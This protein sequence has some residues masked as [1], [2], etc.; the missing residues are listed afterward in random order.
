MKKSLIE[1]AFM[2]EKR[3]KVLLLLQDGPLKMG[4]ILK[5]LDTNRQGLLPQI[6]ILEDYHLIIKKD[7]QCSLTTIG[8]MVVKQMSPLL[9]IVAVLDNDIDYWGSREL[10][11]I[12]PGLLDRF[13]ELGPCTVIE[14]DI[15]DLYEM[16][17]D[18]SENIRASKSMNM[19]TTFL[20]PDFFTL[21]ADYLEH[22][23][24]ISMVLSKEL[25]HKISTDYRD[26]FKGLMKRGRVNM[27]VS[28]LEMPFLSVAYSDHCIFLR[29]LKKKL[30]FDSKQLMCCSPCALAWGKDFFNNYLEHSAPM[31]DI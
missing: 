20:Y 22:G 3:K 1:I 7:D 25:A 6:K 27:F 8:E 28:R 5:A 12:P 19:V 30:V 9:G 17:R 29:L 10:S 16:N 2:S 31:G 11:F 26:E 23:V 18:F 14:P 13:C 24:E 21:F 15:A 4:S